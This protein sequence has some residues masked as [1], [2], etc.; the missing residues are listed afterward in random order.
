MNLAQFKN[1]LFFSL[2]KCYCALVAKRISVLCLFFL[3]LNIVTNHPHT[4]H[5]HTSTSVGQNFHLRAFWL[6]F[7]NQWSYGEMDTLARFSAPNRSRNNPQGLSNYSWNLPVVGNLFFFEWNFSP[8]SFERFGYRATTN[9]AMG[10][11]IP[12]LDSAHQIGPETTLQDILIV[13]E[14]GGTG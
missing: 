7:F 14:S 11:W 13:V 2:L 4:W 8:P 5:T 9:G 10:K 6:W 3:S 12:Q 1:I